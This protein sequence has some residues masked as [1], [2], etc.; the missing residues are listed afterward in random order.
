MT[1]IQWKSYFVVLYKAVEDKSISN[2][3]VVDGLIKRC[4][5]NKNLKFVVY[6]LWRVYFYNDVQTIEWWKTLFREILDFVSVAETTDKEML[7]PL[8]QVVCKKYND[9]DI[10]NIIYY[11]IKETK[12]C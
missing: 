11:L 8:G 12:Q 7:I 10:T 5:G 1:N 6:H 4:N 9:N 2:L 3:E